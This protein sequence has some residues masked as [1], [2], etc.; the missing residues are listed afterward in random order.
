[1]IQETQYISQSP[2]IKSI[3]KNLTL[4][5]SLFISS[6]L[7]GEKHTGKQALIR[8]LFPKS[9]YVDGNNIDEL[10]KAL[11]TYNEVIIYNFETIQNISQLNFE[12][13]RIIAIANQVQNSSLIEEKFAFIYHM[14]P[15]RERMEDVQ[16]LIEHYSQK[17]SHALMIENPRPIALERVDL[18]E[19]IKSLKA[20]IYKQL[21][22]ANLEAEEI[23]QILFEYLYKH[24]EGNNAYREHIALY[25]R[26]LIQ[27][28]L[29]K[30]KSQ[31]KLSSVLGLNRNTLR[32]KI[33]EHHLD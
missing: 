24:M 20:S 15:L 31:L 29:A 1:M 32:K 12:N 10:T 25:E 21:I 13:K 16:L 7:I 18:S 8:S 5:Q 26:P 33:H 27:A 2:E 3:I 28:G 17:I 9:I 23:E 22:T 19:N 30:F 6:I 11:D 4:T 14:P